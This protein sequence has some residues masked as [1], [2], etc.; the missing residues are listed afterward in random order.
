MAI[1]SETLPEQDAL[2]ELLDSTQILVDSLQT[3]KLDVA[4]D[5]L[6]RRGRAIRAVEGQ[7]A[8]GAVDSDIGEKLRAIHELGENVRLPFAARRE[9]LRDKL[10]ELGQTRKVQAS[11][12]PFRAKEK[13]DLDVSA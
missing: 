6:R 10:R 4:G 2:S 7:I 9:N 5:M 1:T 12:A 3:S 8:A 11:L 13:G